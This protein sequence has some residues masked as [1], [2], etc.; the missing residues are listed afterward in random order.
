MSKHLDKI[1]KLLALAGSGNPHEA[2]LALS[3]AQALMVKHGLD[4][5]DIELASVSK[6]SVGLKQK[7]PSLWVAS[8]MN[9]VAKAFGAEVILNNDFQCNKVISHATF[10]AINPNDE[11]ASYCFDV[12]YRQLRRDRADYIN[13]LHGNCKKSSKTARADWYCLGWVSTLD[14]KLLPLVVSPRERMII[15]IWM[16]KNLN[17][18]ECV[19]RSTADIKKASDAFYRGVKDGQN[20]SLSVPVTGERTYIASLG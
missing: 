18:K 4:H 14:E 7:R 17:L 11:I 6:R 19:P 12:L 1:K 13:C 5:I 20:A 9:I 16:K 15:D 10:I 3:R 2:A 8:L